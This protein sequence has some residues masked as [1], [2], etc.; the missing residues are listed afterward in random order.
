VVTGQTLF[1]V[2]TVD[3]DV[4]LVLGTEFVH[5]LFDVSHAFLTITHGLGGVIGVAPGAI[6]FWEKL[7]SEGNIHE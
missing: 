4:E 1:V 3:R 2:V 6:P 7:G 5:H